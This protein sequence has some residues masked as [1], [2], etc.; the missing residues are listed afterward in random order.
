MGGTTLGVAVRDTAGCDSV[1]TVGNAVVR[2]AEAGRPVVGGTATDSGVD[3]VLDRSAV[4]QSQLPVP[5]PPVTAFCLATDN[6]TGG[7]EQ[8]Q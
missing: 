2:V 1:A 8:A 3:I 4:L 7:G 6:G 5:E